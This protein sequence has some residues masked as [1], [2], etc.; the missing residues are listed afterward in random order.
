MSWS[1][2]RIAALILTGAMELEGASLPA[3]PGSPKTPLILTVY[4]FNYARIPDWRLARTQKR[5]SEFFVRAGIQIEWVDRTPLPSNKPGS[6]VNPREL[7]PSDLIL[8]IV[9]RFDLRADGLRSSVFGF[10]AESQITI[11]NERMEEVAQNAEATLP[12]IL[13]I[14]IAHELGHALLGPDSHS[15]DG[16]MRPRLQAAD[17]RQ[18]QC[19]TL[20]FTPE[21]AERMRSKVSQ[22]KNHR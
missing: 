20:A 12:E 3:A 11:I 7:D 1:L 4:I 9:P 16:I 19:K 10:A 22:L 17:F 18:A 15:E 6:T 2:I 5:V 13:A 8:R 14:V 21:Q